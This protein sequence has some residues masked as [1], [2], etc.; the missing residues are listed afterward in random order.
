MCAA[1]GEIR[2]VMANWRCVDGQPYEQRVAML[3]HFGWLKHVL[4]TGPEGCAPCH[5]SDAAFSDK[6][7]ITSGT[8]AYGMDRFVL[9]SILCC[10]VLSMMD[11]GDGTKR[12]GSSV[13][14]QKCSKTLLIHISV[15]AQPVCRAHT[16]STR[17]CF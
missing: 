6:A 5:K 17:W 11:S 2:S 13:L 9:R 8:A 7:A 1:L 4:P 3:L 10:T 16:L 15:H 14:R 12:A